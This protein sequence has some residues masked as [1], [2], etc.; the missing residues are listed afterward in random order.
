LF[1]G[2]ISIITK[3]KFHMQKSKKRLCFSCVGVTA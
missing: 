2:I 1:A 3:P